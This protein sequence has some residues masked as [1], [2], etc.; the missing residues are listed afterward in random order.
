M[1]WDAVDRASAG[2]EAVPIPAKITKSAPVIKLVPDDAGDFANDGHRSRHAVQGRPPARLQDALRRRHPHG[3]GPPREARHR[4]RVPELDPGELHP[5]QPV[6]LRLPPRRHPGQADRARPSSKALPR[7]SSR[8]SPTPRTTATS[9]TGVQVYIEDCVGC[10][11][12]VEVC[13]AKTKALVMTPIEELRAAGETDKAEFFDRLPDNVLDGIKPRHAQ[14]QPVLP[15]AVRVQRRLRRL[16]RDAVRQ[17]GHP[18]LRRPDDHR[19]R[20][21]LLLDLR[22]HVPDLALLRQRGREGPGLGQL[23]LRGQRRI[24]LRHAPGRRRQPAR[25]WPPRSKPPWP[26][27]TTPEL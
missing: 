25:S 23:P 3:H 11:N 7:D 18:A 26:P 20:H 14:G 24:R 16:R 13:P 5:V 21:G 19:Q 9:S 12:C 4:H 27:G 22:R 15:A 10:G 2:L 17:A 1:N 6:R 8:S